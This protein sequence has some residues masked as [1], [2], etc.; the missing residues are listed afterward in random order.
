MLVDVARQDG[1]EDGAK[2]TPR[3]DYG[4][5]DAPLT[6]IHNGTKSKTDY[7]LSGQRDF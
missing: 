3:V 2:R 6:T 7:P 1:G 4:G 5:Q